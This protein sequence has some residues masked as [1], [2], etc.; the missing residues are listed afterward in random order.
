M[1][2]CLNFYGESVSLDN[3]EN[4]INNYL[5]DDANTYHILFTT[6]D[7]TDDSFSEKF[8]GSY[9]KKYVRDVEVISNY[10][11]RYSDV[12]ICSSNPEKSVE[13][14]VSDLYIKSKS[15]DTINS[16]IAETGTT[17]DLII[18]TTTDLYLNCPVFG[19][20]NVD[21]INDCGTSTIFIPNGF[22]FDIH[23]EESCS[24]KIV[25]TDYNNT[26]KV[27]EQ[28]ND[29]DTHVLTIDDK[30][31]YHPETCYFRYLC[32]SGLNLVRLFFSAATI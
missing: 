16:F 15:I 26:V 21:I 23:G 19:K 11:D 10:V 29:L 24:T 28:L 13:T 12:E 8:A 14:V 17:F 25:I 32:A 9:V 6:W 7:T 5:K 2:I 3:A 1:N 22:N 20:R 4:I 27:T 18:T 31:I 30:K